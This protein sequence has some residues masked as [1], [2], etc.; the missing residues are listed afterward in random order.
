[1]QSRNDMNPDDAGKAREDQ[2]RQRLSAV[3][4]E[5]LKRRKAQQRSRSGLSPADHEQQEPASTD[6]KR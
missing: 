6:Q 1:M 5:N 4:R 2:R 3:L